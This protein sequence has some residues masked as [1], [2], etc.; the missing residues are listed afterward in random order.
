MSSNQQLY[1]TVCFY[2]L[3]IFLS[4]KSEEEGEVRLLTKEEEEVDV[5]QSRVE[6]GGF[7]ACPEDEAKELLADVS[8]FSWFSILPIS[9]HLVIG[10]EFCCFSL[11]FHFDLFFFFFRVYGHCSKPV[12]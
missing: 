3:T 8:S 5:L 9:L 2:C 4:D 1:T 6:A 11:A 7:P 10:T 12:C